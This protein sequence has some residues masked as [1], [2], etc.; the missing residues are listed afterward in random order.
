MHRR[1]SKYLGSGYA[2]KVHVARPDVTPTGTSA[3]GGEEQWIDIHGRVSAD[4]P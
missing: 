4:N 2:E 3:A 1:T